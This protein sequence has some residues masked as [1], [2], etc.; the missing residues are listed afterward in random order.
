M[1]PDLILLMPIA[2]QAIDLGEAHVR[3]IV[4]SAVGATPGVWRCGSLMT[5]P[6]S[7]PRT[8]PR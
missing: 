3:T 4:R 6:T 2:R 1:S 8:P 7:G 5:I